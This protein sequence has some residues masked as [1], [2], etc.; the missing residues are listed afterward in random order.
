MY[1]IRPCFYF[2]AL[3]STINRLNNIFNDTVFYFLV[4]ESDKSSLKSKDTKL[5][6]SVFCFS[7]RSGFFLIIKSQY[8]CYL[9]CSSR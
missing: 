5:Y 6:T 7:H 3:M 8:Y 9:F 4:H 2:L 1:E